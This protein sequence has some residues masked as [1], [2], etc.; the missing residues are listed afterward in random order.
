[1]REA[2][3]MIGTPAFDAA[4]RKFLPDDL[5]GMAPLFSAIAHGAAAGAHQAAYLEVYSPRLYRGNEKYLWRRLGALG[6][7][8]AAL[9]HFFTVPW[10]TPA[11]GLDDRSKALMLGN[12][13][14]ALRAQGRLPD[15]E[16]ATAAAVQAFKRLQGDE[17][18]VAINSSNLSEVRLALGNVRGAVAAA[19]EAGDFAERAKDAFRRMAYRASHADAL[20]QAGDLEGAAALFAEAERLQAE[21]Q[22]DLPRSTPAGLPLLRPIARHGARG[23]GA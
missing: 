19:H 6:Q 22:P 16:E 3:K 21:D 9:A 15:G 7:D 20:H 10:S 23:G 11:P 13:A 4:L 5:A 17:S 8:L 1:M 2:A 12:A 18:D 14:F